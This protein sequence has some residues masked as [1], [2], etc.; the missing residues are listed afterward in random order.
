[1]YTAIPEN[2]K[3][4]VGDSVYFKDGYE[5]TFFQS[6]LFLYKNHYRM[7]EL[8]N[9]YDTLNKKFKGNIDKWIASI[10]AKDIDKIANIEYKIEE[11]KQEIKH[12][13]TIHDI[14]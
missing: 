1:M 13:K 5:V 11:L 12:L 3:P 14:K 7:A 8:I 4:L 6:R 10:I 2:P 9:G